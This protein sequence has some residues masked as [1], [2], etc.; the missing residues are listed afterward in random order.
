MFTILIPETIPA[1]NKGEEAIFY[2]I[3]STLDFIPEKKIYLFSNSPS[4]DKKQYNHHV[5]IISSIG[6]LANPINKK[7]SK[8]S[9]LFKCIPLHIVYALLY[10]MNKHIARK[11]FTS[12][13]WKVYDEIDLIIAGHDNAFN[14][15]HNLLLLFCKL[16]G[17]HSVIYGCSIKP[18]V[19]ENMYNKYLTRFCLNMV[20]LI[21][22]REEI[23]QSIL[24]EKVGVRKG[25]VKLTA[26]KAF[27]L[28]P[29]D[30][31]GAVKLLKKHDI[32]YGS[33]VI[34]GM[35]V[36][37]KTGILNLLLKN[38]TEFNIDKHTTIISQ[39]VDFIIESIGAKVVFFP[40]SIGPGE[41]DDDRIAAKIVFDKCSHK[42]RIR[43]INED[44]PASE[45]KGMIGCC[46]FFV[47]ER[48]HS[49][50]AATS[51]YVPSISI[52]HS[53]DY[54]T[55]G[56]LGLMVGMKDRIY[57]VETLDFI[58]LKQFFLDAWNKRNDIRDSLIEKI[59]EVIK[60]VEDN[61]IYLKKFLQ[62]KNIQ[63]HG[64]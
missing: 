36:V 55:L 1:H 39:F 11:L 13:I 22:V 26:D 43:L 38:K 42:Q 18:F 47:G 37:H 52:S 44:L 40:H 54:R 61:K 60:K 29:V 14:M 24:T 33:E 62:E 15:K 30:K 50:I 21:T 49:V 31:K 16:I 35:T 23:S 27:L 63:T 64:N 5:E 20:G 10:R 19:L 56:I 9:Y 41:A 53:K 51:M 57:Y 32:L 4:Y 34:I 3:L 48:T 58:T 2:G 8:L 7:H 59:P 17:K 12:H 45:L 6:S 25:L 28:K 46:D